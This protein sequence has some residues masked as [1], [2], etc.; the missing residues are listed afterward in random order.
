MHA[1]AFALVLALS[2]LTAQ[3]TAPPPR[4]PS[5]PPAGV[6]IVL[7]KAAATADF[8]DTHTGEK[9]RTR[10]TGTGPHEGIIAPG[11]RLAVVANYGAQE[12]GGTLTLLDLEHDAAL[13]PLELGELVRPHGL[14]FSGG[15]LLVTAEQKGALLGVDLETRKVVK[16]V[17][18]GQEVSHM[19]AVTPDGKR[20]FVANI[21]SG[22][23]T[24]VDLEAWRVLSSVPTGAGAE[25]VDV[26]PDGKEVWV[27]NRSAGT[28]SV[29]DAVALEVRAKLDCPGF[30][31]RV[32]LT[33]DGAL[34]L[35]SAAQAGE[36]VVFDA[37]TKELK[38]RVPMALP[39]APG[40]TPP[41]AA[42]TQPIGILIPPHGREAYV[43][44][45]A[46]DRVAVLDLATLKV[47]RSFTTGSQPDGLAWY[48]PRG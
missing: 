35:V 46:I 48:A 12:P 18:T 20:A 7:N 43:A 39:H 19:V 2:A 16:S 42:G 37:R 11:G 38:R 8:I 47:T 30:P 23:V 25:G 24:A 21:G 5:G 45:A 22:S 32:K 33:P 1:P 4:E 6:L 17:P 10:P 29:V 3:G 36:V 15:L 14:A 27:T 26:S 44:C 40:E 28:V 34:A 31:I 41:A 13:A 9:L